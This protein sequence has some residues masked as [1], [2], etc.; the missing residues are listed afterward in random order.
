M[1]F[2]GNDRSSGYKYWPLL[3]MSRTLDASTGLKW[4]GQGLW[5]LLLTS[6]VND[7]DFA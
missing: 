6:S 7:W 1:I 4:K 3:A 2:S 5:I